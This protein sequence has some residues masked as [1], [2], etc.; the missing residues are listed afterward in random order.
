[1]HLE[2]PEGSVVGASLP[3]VPA[4]VI[5]RNEHLA[6]GITNSGVDVQ[7]LY[8][9]EGNATHYKHSSSPTGWLPYRF[10]Q[11]TIQIKRGRPREVCLL[12]TSDAADE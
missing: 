12:Y 10:R 4:I 8:A 1:M 2:S 9:M 6:W 5:G 3:G 11:E 7:D